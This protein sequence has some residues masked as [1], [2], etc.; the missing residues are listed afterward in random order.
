MRHRYQGNKERH[1]RDKTDSDAALE[2]GDEDG[3]IL[4]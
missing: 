3:Q 4:L 2:P 1:S